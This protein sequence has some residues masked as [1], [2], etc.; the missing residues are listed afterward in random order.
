MR[1]ILNLLEVSRSKDLKP[2]KAEGKNYEK[3]LENTEKT[4]EK[5]EI[6]V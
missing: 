5:N 2:E 3:V 6:N 4:T 1:N